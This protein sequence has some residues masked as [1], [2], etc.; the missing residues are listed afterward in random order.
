MSFEDYLNKF[1]EELKKDKNFN[2][3]YLEA[4]I[5]AFAMARA[6]IF[7]IEMEEQKNEK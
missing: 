1:Y 5:N 2:G 4:Y 7:L 6:L 3:N